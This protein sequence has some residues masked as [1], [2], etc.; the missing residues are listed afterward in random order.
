MQRFPILLSSILLVFAAACGGSSNPG[1]I[2]DPTPPG[3]GPSTGPNITKGPSTAPPPG[4]VTNAGAP[5]VGNVSPSGQNVSVHTP[6]CVTFSESVQ[7]ATVSSTTLILRVQQGQ[8]IQSTMSNFGG[9]QFFILVP[10]GPLPA[11]KTIEIVASNAIHDID[12]NPLTVPTGGVIGS[13]KTEATVDAVANPSVVAVFPANNAKNVSPGSANFGTGASAFPG[14]PAQI[15]TVFSRSIGASTILGD[16]TPPLTPDKVGLT[17]I[18]Q[19]DPDGTGPQPVQNKPLIPG[20]GALLLPFNENRVWLT[21]PIAPLDPGSKV[22]IAAG[23][24]IKSDSVTPTALSPVFSSSF[25][26]ASVAPPQ[27]VNIDITPATA[28][29]ILTLPALLNNVPQLPN[30]TPNPT[31][32]GKFTVGVVFDASSL[33]TDTVEI[34]LHDLAGI[35]AKLFTQKARA[36][37]GQTNYDNLSIFDSKGKA[38]LGQGAISISARTKRGS[39]ASTWVSGPPLLIDTVAPTIKSIGPPSD[40]ATILTTIRRAA[41]YGTA[42]ESVAS[43][44]IS[45]IESPV[46][47]LVLP[48]IPAG[49]QVH[50]LSTNGNLFFSLPLVDAPP[51]DTPA[52]GTPPAEPK[53]K[54][55]VTLS[56]AVGNSSTAQDIQFISRGRIGGPSIASQDALTVVV[57]DEDTLATVANAVV[58]V[59]AATPSGTSGSQAVKSVT[60]SGATG[61]TQASFL[62][63]TDFTSGAPAL[64]VTA[65]APG[66]DITT[67]IGVPAS[68]ISIPI[69]KTRGTAVVDP[70]ISVSLSGAPAGSTIDLFVS[71]RPDLG[72]RFSVTSIPGI[73]G[74][75][76]ISTTAVGALRPL[77]LVAFV[78]NATNF[79][80]LNDASNFPVVPI[81]LNGVSSVTATFGQAYSQTTDTSDDPVL[82]PPIGGLNIT[83]PGAPFDSTTASLESGLLVPGA[84]VG[85][86]G[87]IA[88]GEGRNGNISGGIAAIGINF[89]PKANSGFFT[90]DPNQNPPFGTVVPAP[91]DPNASD[92]DARVLLRADDASGRV[93]RALVR[94]ATGG[95]PI[96]DITLPSV[97]DTLASTS[98]VTLGKNSPKIAWT[99]AVPTSDGFYIIRLK[100]KQ[101]TP[102]R[103]WRIYVRRSDANLTV[104]G[105]VSLQLP[106]LVGFGSLAGSPIPSSGA[107][108]DQ[109]ADAISQSGIDFNDFFFEDLR[110]A[111]PNPGT[112]DPVTFARGSKLEI[113]Y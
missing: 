11:N 32:A 21:T 89:N 26:V 93:S 45:Q 49:A 4:S 27:F 42:S 68:F 48:P 9:G 53:A 35:N 96:G 56:D 25:T 95:G 70:T 63:G 113:I 51:V 106:S 20:V 111:N 104:G 103:E 109:I 15:I 55:R 91:V 47:T 39:V 112:T 12:G 65:S 83:L 37:A 52:T 97:P 108:I 57:Y 92:T 43:L 78:R 75:P 10:N 80:Y 67:V 58:L 28:S 84:R 33:A 72:D 8:T 36:G 3:G 6:V 2:F 82:V 19:F 59:D 60:L 69:R 41:V 38:Q 23:P 102:V 99:D 1:A 54:A 94:S 50:L 66:Y 88:I 31:Y 7:T 17:I 86:S 30:N 87:Q 90:V 110:A 29:E 98:A 79:T 64:T 24:G 34:Q 101:A 5:A 85:V 81:A 71:A 13:F 46:G 62:A 40:S 107:L 16:L 18:E 100:M 76:I 22:T 61:T 44:L 77:D 105:Q 74:S 14:V 73:G